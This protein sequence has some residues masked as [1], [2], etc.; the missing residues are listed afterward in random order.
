LCEKPFTANAEEAE[1]VVRVAEASDV[2]VMEAFH[3]RYHPIADRMLELVDS[4][5]LGDIER[6]E[7]TMCIP[8]PL[9]G[10]IRY[11]YELAGGAT[12]D[13]GCYAVHL[14]RTLARAEPEV[15]SARARLSSARVD[16]SM[17]AD[18]HFADG[19]VGRVTCSLFSARLFSIRARV[20]GSKGE[21]SVVNP[22]GPQFYHHIKM[23]SRSGNFTER[24]T[25]ESTYSFQLKAFAAAVLKGRPVLTPPAEGLAN[26]RVIDD[27]YRA[28]GLPV[29]GMG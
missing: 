9:P 7:T 2:V 27:I 4:G 22:V 16:R 28:A 24:V 15:V 1:R 3:W 11:R 26:M 21:L 12:M 6:I 13:T 17:Q 18:M 8:L 10:N 19:R 5:Q 29:R 14:L 23:R 20:F 25:R